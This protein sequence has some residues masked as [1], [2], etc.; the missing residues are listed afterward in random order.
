MSDLTDIASLRLAARAGRA[1]AVLPVLVE[2]VTE[3]ASKDG[4]PFL[5]VQLVDARDRFVLRVWSDNGQFS[6]A[7]EL[8]TG[9]CLKLE[10]EF[11]VHA[12]F[13]LEAKGWS[14]APLTVAEQEEFLAGPADLRARQEEDYK[15]LESAVAALRDPRLKGL[16]Q[17]FLEKFGPRFRRSA[18]ARFF[19][20]A[21]RGGLVEH[22]AQ[23]MRY[24]EAI[25]AANPSLHRDL[26]LSGVLFHDCG[27]LWENCI[28]EGGFAMPF[29]E[30][31]ELLGHINIGIELVNSLW[32]T[33]PLEEWKDL[34]P[35]N[36]DVRLHL[37]HL[38][39]AHHGELA[40]GSPVQPKTPEAIALHYIDNL[41]AKLEMLSRG[42]EG[43]PTVAA[44]IY[45]K[46]KPL[47]VRLVAPLGPAAGV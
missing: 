39:A 11:V 44:R 21:R 35:E 23:M 46:V 12:Q 45:D 36:E 1:R 31:G 4:K 19:H 47:N 28:E 13:G 3:K 42:Y 18:A 25:C 27:K 30:R 34:R 16:G 24:A 26:L 14:F 32:K 40:F 20:H 38:V 41:D 10:G 33:L 37:L 2:T 17:A 29:D 6:A 43:G 7:R 15:F 8:A 5:E 9:A 22:V